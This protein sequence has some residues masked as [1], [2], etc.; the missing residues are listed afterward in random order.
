MS[1][2]K[3]KQKLKH[4]IKNIKKDVEVDVLIPPKESESK[5]GEK[6]KEKEKSSAKKEKEKESAIEVL[7]YLNERCGKGY[8]L[9]E[10]NLTGITA[11]L[12]DKWT[13]EQLKSIIDT[14]AKEWIGNSDMNKHL[15]PETLFRP[16]KIEK[17]WQQVISNK[18]INN[19]NKEWRTEPIRDYSVEL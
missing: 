8:R 14:K 19:G 15:N 11:R 13:I 9:I 17:Y 2:Y 12:K 6:E 3:H 16:S 18:I 7:L 1:K 4:N 10:T 5:L